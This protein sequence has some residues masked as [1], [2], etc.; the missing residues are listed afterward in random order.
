MRCY[1]GEGDFAGVGAG[2]WVNSLD[3]CSLQ[4]AE[5]DGDR[6]YAERGVASWV[7]DLFGWEGSLDS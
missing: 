2:G 4:A 1:G 6:E 3:Y 5:G 7:E